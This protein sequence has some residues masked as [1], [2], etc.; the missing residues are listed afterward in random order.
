MSFHHCSTSNLYTHTNYVTH[1][2][3][4]TFAYNPFCFCFF[5]QHSQFG[6][7]EYLKKYSPIMLLSGPL[8]ITQQK[9][10]PCNIRLTILNT[11]YLHTNMIHFS[12]IK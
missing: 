8:H 12:L 6:C 11:V 1:L 3:C 9:K 2:Y 5:K 10:T 7:F 4:Q